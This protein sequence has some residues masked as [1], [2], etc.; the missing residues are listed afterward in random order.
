M[1]NIQLE[2][3]HGRWG[4]IL[5]CISIISVHQILVKIKFQLT[6]CA[7][8][9]VKCL[10]LEING[11]KGAHHKEMYF[12][13]RILNAVIV[14]EC[15][16]GLVPKLKWKTSLS[17]CRRDHVCQ[18]IE[19][20][21]GGK[22]ARA[23]EGVNAPLCFRTPPPPPDGCTVHGSWK[24]VRSKHV[25]APCPAKTFIAF[26]F[27]LFSRWL[28]YSLRNWIWSLTCIVVMTM[29]PYLMGEKRMTRGG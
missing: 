25:L 21:E 11:S 14:Y 8:E 19:L 28:R 15:D 27:H 2:N 26:F 10:V 20:K 6:A 12:P 5:I 24:L 3:M 17:P 18:E 16:S 7:V 1:W 29:W 13:C 4:I 9:Y 23:R 22:E